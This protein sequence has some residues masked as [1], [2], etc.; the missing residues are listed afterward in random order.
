MTQSSKHTVSVQKMT[1]E[2]LQSVVDSGSLL[3]AAARFELQRRGVVVKV[4]K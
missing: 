3:Q 4:K 1:N 2:Q